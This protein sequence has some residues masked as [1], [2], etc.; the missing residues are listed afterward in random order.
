MANFTCLDCSLYDISLQL[1][2]YLSRFSVN[3]ESNI[4]E[5]Q[6]DQ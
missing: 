5:Q 6:Y 2:S 4:P 3:V 1:E